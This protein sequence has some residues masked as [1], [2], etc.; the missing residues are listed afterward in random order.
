M[1]NDMIYSPESKSLH[2]WEGFAVQDVQL[3]TVVD[4]DLGF[5]VP[6]TGPLYNDSNIRGGLIGGIDELDLVGD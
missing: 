6:L 1:V 4:S 2:A 3:P 5:T